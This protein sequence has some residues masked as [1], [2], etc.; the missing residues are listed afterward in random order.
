MWCHHRNEQAMTPYTAPGLK[1][2]EEIA[3]EIWE[4]PVESIMVKTRKREVVEARQVL[5]AYR[6]QQT[7]KSS[8]RVGKEYSK[9]HATVLHAIKTVNNLRETDKVFRYKYEEFN[10]RVNQLTR[11]K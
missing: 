3:A 4:I 2:I 8:N 7:G 1:T 11:S 9:D 6:K 5:M 10:R